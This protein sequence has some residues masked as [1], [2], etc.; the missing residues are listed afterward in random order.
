MPMAMHGVR[1]GRICV[2]ICFQLF[3]FIPAFFTKLNLGTIFIVMAR[4]AL[5]LVA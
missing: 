3:Q 1:T 2:A 4:M 5:V